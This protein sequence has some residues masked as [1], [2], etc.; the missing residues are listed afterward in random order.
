MEGYNKMQQVLQVLFKYD[1]T[2]MYQCDETVNKTFCEGSLITFYTGGHALFYL[3]SSPLSNPQPPSP[4]FPSTSSDV[5][6]VPPVF[7]EPLQDCC[8]D[9]G[10]DIRL[11]GAITGSQPIKVT[12][13]HNGQQ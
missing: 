2:A 10:S 12:W 11:S 4:G 13:L 7:Q 1:E 3:W 5:H 9:E 6:L 8:V